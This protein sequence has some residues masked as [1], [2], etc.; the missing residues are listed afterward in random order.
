MPWA[1][2]YAAVPL[3]ACAHSRAPGTRLP[4]AVSLVARAHSYNPCIRLCSRA[5]YGTCT[6]IVPLASYYATVP[7]MTC[8]H[9]RAPGTRQHRRV[10]LRRVHN[11]RLWYETTDRRVP[12]GA[13]SFSR[14]W[15]ECTDCRV[16]RGRVHMTAAFTPDYHDTGSA[17]RA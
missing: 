2:D 15:P 9:S 5:P 11:P 6:T 3:M 8:A 12:R 4:T 7:L 13:R 1:S 10:P 16:P 14:L 17:L